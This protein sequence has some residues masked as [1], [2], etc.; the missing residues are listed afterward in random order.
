MFYMAHHQSYSKKLI[1]LKS[2]Q[3]FQLLHL[4]SVSLYGYIAQLELMDTDLQYPEEHI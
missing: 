1:I 4:R 3:N 2:P